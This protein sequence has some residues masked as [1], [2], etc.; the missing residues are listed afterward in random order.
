MQC[1]VHT[2]YLGEVVALPG[3]LGAGKFTLMKMLARA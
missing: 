1:R 2:A 3:Q